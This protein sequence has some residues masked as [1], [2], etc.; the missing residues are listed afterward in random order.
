MSDEPGIKATFPVIRLP[1]E[2]TEYV[3]G[4][5][6]LSERLRKSILL[7]STLSGLLLAVVVALVSMVPLYRT[8]R[9]QRENELLSVL[10]G[11]AVAVEIFLWEAREIAKQMAS[12]TS[13]LENLQL[14]NADKEQSLKASESIHS[15]LAEALNSALIA[16]SAYCFDRSGTPLVHVGFS[17]PHSVQ[18]W[19][20][21]HGEDSQSFCP[22]NVQGTYYLLY[23]IPVRA[24]DDSVLGSLAVLYDFGALRQRLVNLPDVGIHEDTYIGSMD[25]GNIQILLQMQGR[26]SQNTPGKPSSRIIEALRRA[27]EDH[28]GLLEPDKSLTEPELFA[29]RP[30]AGTDWGIAIRQTHRTLLADIN[31]QLYHIGGIVLLLIV[32]IAAGMLLLL[33]PLAGK[34][35]MHSRE[36]EDRVDEQTADLDAERKHLLAM[37]TELQE[38]KKRLE[39]A[40]E[41]LEAFS[42]T[43]AHD[44]RTP[45]V[46]VQGYADL[47]L[48]TEHI[49]GND[50]C[51]QML[52]RIAS[53]SRLMAN[54]IKSL[55]LYARAGKAEINR[56]EVN[57]SQMVEEVAADLR[58]EYHGREVDLRVQPDIKVSADKI[59]LYTVMENLIGNAWKYTCRTE[60]P[61]IEVGVKKR[62][63][64]DVYFVRDNGTGFDMM[65]A[66]RLFQP[67]QRLHTD[68]EFA[69]TGIGLST[70]KRIIEQ[71]GGE[72]WAEGKLGEGAAFYFTLP[73]KR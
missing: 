9:A 66:E 67:F 65:F 15:S 64:Q 39:A 61:Q 22:I 57:L 18:D 44:L 24:Q 13:I 41:D 19:L 58:E 21:K 71:H 7:Y 62:E 69:G 55:L 37:T 52:S 60:N 38:Q 53:K 43:V 54:Q 3:M 27:A 46:A 32:G 28:T 50:D 1:V 63:G 10:H 59:L 40:N 73:A 70:V 20:K 42:R 56:S 8:M 30:I 23:R 45:L 29:F 25:N 31:E 36:L 48:M 12:R 6:H 51:R 68:A 17:L 4:E 26:E 47:L 35:V 2:V 14:L 34:M 5:T 11:R 49:K 16:E 72:V 33:Q